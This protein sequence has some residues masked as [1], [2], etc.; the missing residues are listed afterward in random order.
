MSAFI[1]YNLDGNGNMFSTKEAAF[2]HSEEND[3]FGVMEV[4]GDAEFNEGDSVTIM[5]STPELEERYETEKM[6]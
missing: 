3:T 1:S 2:K 6:N 4:L 5:G